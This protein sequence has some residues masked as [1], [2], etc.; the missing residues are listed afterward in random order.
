MIPVE[1]KLQNNIFE[2][3]ED[4]IIHLEIGDLNKY[5]KRP[6]IIKTISTKNK[7]EYSNSA[8]FFGS[9]YWKKFL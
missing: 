9:L 6:I 3:S 4:P 5:V 2:Y 8:D 7:V 1:Q